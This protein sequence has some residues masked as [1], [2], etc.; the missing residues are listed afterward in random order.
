MSDNKNEVV[1][2]LRNFASKLA[3]GGSP[4]RLTVADGQGGISTHAAQPKKDPG[5]A[6]VK[7]NLPA[8]GQVNTSDSPTSNP[9]RLTVADGQGGISSHAAQPKTDPGEAELKAGL[10][11]DGV[12][13]KSASDRV[14][15]IRNAMTNG[16]GT[17]AP[18]AAS[19]PAAAFTQKQATPAVP[20]IDMSQDMLAKI[21]S[22]ALSTEEGIAFIHNLFEKQAGEAAA[23][24]QIAEALRVADAYDSVQHVKSA[25]INDVL[26]KAAAIHD[27]LAQVITEDEA[28]SILKIASFHQAA[29]LELD[30]PL[31][32]Q[33]HAL[34][35]ED[36]AL[37]EAAEE[38]EGQEG[39]LPVDEAIP[40]GGEELGEEEIL[41]LLQEMIASGEIT[42]EDVKAALEATE[43]EGAPAPEQEQPMA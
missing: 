1:A 22:T 26:E 4:D 21:A 31:L 17:A 24:E 29:L 14:N 2:L 5:E 15:A 13:R 36:A 23:R 35:M 19:T 40:M 32:K 42:E 34:G 7:H 18:V 9:D 37:M 28:D 3:S 38:A 10:P 25:A 27:E 41:A 12:V 11:A 6:E 30:H 20:S 39:A 8:D 16:R 33:A 43:G